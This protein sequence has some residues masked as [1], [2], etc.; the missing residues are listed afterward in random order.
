MRDETSVP[1]ALPPEPLAES[2]EPGMTTVVALAEENPV[3]RDP[4]RSTMIRLALPVLA[5]QFLNL[6]VGLFDTFLAGRISAAATVAIGLATYT[7]WLANMG[8]MLVATGTTALVSRYRGGGDDRRA[9][10]F[11]NQSLTLAALLGVVLMIGFY[12]LAPMFARYFLLT[13]EAR[14]IT[15][16]YL[17]IDAVGHMLMSVT[18]VGCAALR[19]VGNMRTPMAIFAVV[20]V[21]NVIVASALTFGIGPIPSIGVTGIVAGTVTARVIGVSLLLAVLYGGKRG[22]RLSLPDLRLSRES[23]AR[24]LRI[25]VPAGGEGLVMGFGQ[26][27]F[28]GIIA[29]VADGAVGQASL[30]AHAIAVRVESLTYLP[31]TAWAMATATMIGQALGAGLPRRAKQAGHEGAMQCGLLAVGIAALFF[32]FSGEIYATMSN[33]PLVCGIGAPAFR[34]LALLQPCMAVAIVYI[35]GVRGAG[36]TR[37]PL[38]ISMIGTLGIR[39]S[40]GYFFGIV[41]QGGLLG[42]WA[43]M[44]GDMIWRAIASAARFARGSWLKT[45][46]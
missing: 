27:L 33:D 3:V 6:S 39:L 30:A 37:F 44:F 13:G 1:I 17:R 46:V 40:L 23:L 45:R 43:G 14:D 38:V 41:M 11:A 24:L 29:R 22:L 8:V 20:N 5:E 26:F 32:V 10:H 42:A 12:S 35:G 34:Y 28:F 31:A 25:G 21:V 19:G 4:V 15:V 16:N 18:F 36:D 2:P 7:Q 9:N